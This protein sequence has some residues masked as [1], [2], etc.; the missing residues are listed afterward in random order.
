MNAAPRPCRSTPLRAG[1]ALAILAMLAACSMLP[2]HDPPQVSVAGV[3][4]LEGEGMELRMLV[5]L[6]VQNPNDV[7]IDFDGVYLRLDVLDRTF[8]TGV[9]AAHGTI[10]RFGEGVVS[11]PVTVSIVNVGRYAFSLFQG[12]KV[13]ERINY[14]LEGKL[15]GPG[16]GA[17]R[18]QSQGE[19]SLP[20]LGIAQP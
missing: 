2:F 1:F 15:N 10:P 20:G 7:P 6:R 16:F 19:L 13:P 4:S 5:K 11:V 12:G 14:R 18:F 17:V 3:E 9:S 8:A